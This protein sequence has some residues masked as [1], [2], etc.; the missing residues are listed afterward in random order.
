MWVVEVKWSGTSPDFELRVHRDKQRTILG[1][2]DCANFRGA[3]TGADISIADACNA[4][5][6]GSADLYHDR[7]PDLRVIPGA[8]SS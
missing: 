4:A 2:A 7:A 8:R 3:N 5:H 6:K 1:M